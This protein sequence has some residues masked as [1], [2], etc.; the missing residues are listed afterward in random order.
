MHQLVSNFKDKKNSTD[1]RLPLQQYNYNRVTVK[2]SCF[3]QAT[4]TT[5]IDLSMYY[6]RASVRP[7]QLGGE[8][9]DGEGW[10][11]FG[12][13]NNGRHF[14]GRE[15]LSQATDGECV[16]DRA[17]SSYRTQTGESATG[18]ETL[19]QAGRETMGQNVNKRNPNLMRKIIPFVQG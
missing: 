8:P 9:D 18:R 10:I 2:L 12:C 15:L 16:R 6:L 14:L 1:W 11:F 13:G 7:G 4:A 19:S 17:E 5:Q 3:I